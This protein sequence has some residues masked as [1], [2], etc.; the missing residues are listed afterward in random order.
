MADLREEV[1]IRLRNSLHGREIDTM[2]N[3]VEIPHMLGITPLGKI[4]DPNNEEL[5]LLDP[6]HEF[7]QQYYE[8]VNTK[9]VVHKKIETAVRSLRED[10]TFTMTHPYGEEA[11]ITYVEVER[12]D[13]Q[14]EQ[15]MTTEC[16][17]CGERIDA[18]L[19]VNLAG[20][21]YLTN[22]DIDCPHCDFSNTYSRQLIRR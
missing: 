22:V 7:W 11:D 18:R 20:K 13:R 12:L 10:G 2:E 15:A 8:E 9:H 3:T 6:K 14:P 16:L 17:D 1:A 19:S 5:T 4:H 21:T